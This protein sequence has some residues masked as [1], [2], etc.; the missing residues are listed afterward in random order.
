MVYY[1]SST[2]QRYAIFV[3]PARILQKNDEM[4]ITFWNFVM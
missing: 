2:L 4:Y 1:C 3:I